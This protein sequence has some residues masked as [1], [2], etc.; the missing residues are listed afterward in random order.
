MILYCIIAFLSVYTSA[1]LFDGFDCQSPENPRYISH[2]QCNNVNK[3]VHKKD[4]AIVQKQTVKSLTGYSCNGFKTY[5]V[6]YCGAYS[7]TKHT[8]ESRFNVPMTFTKQEC[9]QMISSRA[10]HTETQ[11]FPLKMN[12]LSSI[13]FYTH[14][15]IKYTGTNIQCVGTQMR[16]S[17]GTINDNLIRQ[18][19]LLMEI[20]SH[21]LMIIHDKVI[22]PTN[23]IELGFTREEFSQDGQRSFIWNS[24]PIECLYMVIMEITLE[25]NDFTVW[26]ND[27]NKIQL[28]ALDTFHEVLCDMKVT[29]T[30]ADN[31]FLISTDQN[32]EHLNHIDSI[33]VD[34]STDL[35]IRFSYLY[36]ELNTMMFTDYNNRNP[37]C[38]TI[39]GTTIDDTINIGNGMFLRNL[40][41]ISVTFTCRKVIVAPVATN[42]CYS[43]AKVS[44]IQGSIWFLSPVNRMLISQA[45]VVPCTSATLPVYRSNS[46]DLV[47]FSPTKSIVTEEK[48]QTYQNRS[49]S[50]NHN[51][52]LYPVR[53]IKEFLD[54]SFLQH[55]SK[56][57]YSFL[58]NVV[59]QHSKCVDIHTNANKMKS[60]IGET[61]ASINTGSFFGL[62]IVWL[63]S[64]CSIA[65]IGLLIIY[66]GYALASW[67]I[68]MALFKDGQLKLW[69][70]L[71]RATFPS[72]FLITSTTNK[73]DVEK[74]VEVEL[75]DP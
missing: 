14:G 4:F 69:A 10:Y 58:S 18:E 13:S 23:Q 25:S 37:L 67:F 72:F 30:T 73:R 46:D 50:S 57:S 2:Q 45:I 34:L 47:V 21:D 3:A 1:V 59:C 52:G 6:S 43:M 51:T 68:R 63:G 48:I 75:P 49:S 54:L 15:A 11:S 26:Y 33:N 60:L 19:H 40:G 35:Q 5:E 56:Y 31:I 12:A 41:D 42:K 71:C 28:S 16:L 44:D 66:T 7:H 39:Q 27:V 9:M 17:D 22:E 61:L 55:V 20:R 70:L 24:P 65:V 36:A 32:V 53:L 74:K 64:R 62:D 29:K 38:K 8:G